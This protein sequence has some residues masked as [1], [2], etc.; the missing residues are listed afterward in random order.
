MKNVFVLDDNK[1]VRV[2]N[3]VVTTVYK[4]LN[5]KLLD[6]LKLMVIDEIDKIELNIDRS[7]FHNMDKY[8]IVKHTIDN[9]N[10]FLN[11]NYIYQL[12]S[13]SIGKGFK[14]DDSRESRKMNNKIKRRDIV[15][16]YLFEIQR[17]NQNGKMFRFHILMIRFKNDV[18]LYTFNRKYSNRIKMEM[19]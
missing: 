8:Q 12:S 11:S 15:S 9:F 1:L 16:M 10:G 3:D 6:R 17:Y 14:I 5:E 19:F 2:E 13:F 7:G 4:R 18:S